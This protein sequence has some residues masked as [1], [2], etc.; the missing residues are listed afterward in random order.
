MTIGGKPHVVC[1]LEG[2]AD[3]LE[4]AF[5]YR[6]RD[7]ADFGTGVN[8]KFQFRISVGYMNGVTSEMAGI[9]RRPY[10]L[11]SKFC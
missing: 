8:K 4:K 2:K 7:N 6:T 5:S 1:C 11:A 10:S 9:S 3:G